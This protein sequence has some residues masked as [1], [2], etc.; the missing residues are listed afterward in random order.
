MGA[1]A[2]EEEAWTLHLT[3]RIAVDRSRLLSFKEIGITHQWHLN[4]F[5]FLSCTLIPNIQVTVGTS[6][7][8][9]PHPDVTIFFTV[10]V[11]LCCW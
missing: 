8:S 7:R 4:T 1:L 10:G 9:Y 5:L 3:F 11:R 2:P 6:F